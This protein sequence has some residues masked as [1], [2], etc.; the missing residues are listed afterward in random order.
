MCIVASVKEKADEKDE[1]AKEGISESMYVSQ[2][3]VT[4]RSTISSSDVALN[5]LHRD[6]SP[7]ATPVVRVE[8]ISTPPRAIVSSK[9]EEKSKPTPAFQPS[10][11]SETPKKPVP[12]KPASSTANEDWDWSDSEERFALRP[13]NSMH[14]T[15]AK[16]KLPPKPK[17][18]TVVSPVSPIS[19][20]SPVS[21]MD[22]TS[23]E[24]IV[25]PPQR[26]GTQK[27]NETQFQRRPNRPE[28][29]SSLPPPPLPS[30]PKPKPP[31]PLNPKPSL[32]SPSPIG[33]ASD[34]EEFNWDDY[35][36]QP[37]ENSE[38]NSEARSKGFFD[39]TPMAAISSESEE[40]KEETPRFPSLEII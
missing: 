4:D 10:K 5:S 38:T 33:D 2:S 30:N 36:N 3:V 28:S 20:V 24:E 22:W 34:S 29:K 14:K 15:P 23:D 40:E 13:A 37:D 8:A 19:P 27:H 6:V 26:H 25:D 21:P 18:E 39:E 12:A 16:S 31:L 11:P 7:I 1:Q 9:K 35:F 32:Y 17:N